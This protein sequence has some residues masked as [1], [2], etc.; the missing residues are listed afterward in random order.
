MSQISVDC[1]STLIGHLLGDGHLEYRSG[2]TRF[3]LHVGLPNIEYLGWIA[4]FLY[5]E[6]MLS[7]KKFKLKRQ[8]G[9][10]GKLYYSTKLQSYSFPWL[11]TYHKNFYERHPFSYFLWVTHTKK[12][13]YKKRIPINIR[14]SLTPLALAIWIQDD[15]TSRGSDFSIA[16]NCFELN[17]INLLIDAL[18]FNYGIQGKALY[19]DGWRIGFSKNQTQILFQVVQPYIHSSMLYKFQTFF[20]DFVSKEDL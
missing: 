17:D 7:K 10:Q 13:T 11:N 9:K 18:K 16:T 3:T 14:Q 5:K 1:H 8:I 12:T 2:S 19:S 4:N 20:R 15:G 6:G